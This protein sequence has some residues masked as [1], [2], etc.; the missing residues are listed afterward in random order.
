[1]NA[2]LR[3]GLALTAVA[4]ASA[5]SL[6]SDTCAVSLLEDSLTLPRVAEISKGIRCCKERIKVRLPLLLVH[7]RPCLVTT[8]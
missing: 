3:L 8:P 7:T 5:A 4:F 6:Q 1:M 2:A